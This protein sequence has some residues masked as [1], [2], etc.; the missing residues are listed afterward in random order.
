[1]TTPPY[2][3]PS[4]AASPEYPPLGTPSGA[5]LGALSP[6]VPGPLAGRRWLARLL[7]WFLMLGISLPLWYVSGDYLRNRA[8]SAA[9]ELGE[10]SV[11]E[12]LLSGWDAV[13]DD[14]LTAAAEFWSTVVWVAVATFAGQLLL[15]ALYDWLLHAFLG[16]TVGKIAAGITVLRI[17]ATGDQLEPGRLGL[18]RAAGRTAL[19]VLLPGLGWLL[20]L[21][22]TISL[23]LLPALLGVLVL[24]AS[25]IECASLRQLSSGQTCW[26][27]RRSGTMVA[28]LS[29]ARQLQQVAELQRRAT[30]GA[31]H[32]ARQAWQAPATQK[33]IEQS[34]AAAQRAWQAQRTQQAVAQT[35]ATAQRA[36][37][38]EVAQAAVQRAREG[39]E[40]IRDAQA[41]RQAL[42]KGKNLTQQ[43]RNSRWGAAMSDRFPKLTGRDGEAPPQENP[44][45]GHSTPPPTDPSVPPPP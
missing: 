4:P 39:A 38:S 24:L 8:Q 9:V 26:H 14:L 12:L 25:V 16:R 40:R 28:R 1:M 2:G 42:D 17:G 19:T 35:R 10:K 7:D 43:L 3:W 41:T 29:W 23:S 20:L 37:E 21:W 32:L 45:T 6:P 31:Q 13:N 15:V 44:P 36:W 5:P 22:A 11:P 33:T 27:D 34:T 30:A 18:A